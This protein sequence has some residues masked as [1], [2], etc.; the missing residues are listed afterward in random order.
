ML[1]AFDSEAA[2]P[3][4]E[5]R[6]RAIARF[7]NDTVYYHLGAHRLVYFQGF[8]ERVG[9]EWPNWPL[10]PWFSM[11]A[12]HLADVRNREYYEGP[13]PDPEALIEQLA[14]IHDPHDHPDILE[15]VTVDGTS[16]W[17]VRADNPLYRERI[18]LL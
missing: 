6:E 14:P 15:C 4:T 13:L 17:R 5:A 7:T 11:P 10:R 9:T 3:C 2:T 1:T 16:S 18:T 12:R 8:T